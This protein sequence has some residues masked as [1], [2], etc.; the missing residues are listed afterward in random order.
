MLILSPTDRN[1]N[2]NQ[3]PMIAHQSLSPM[4]DIFY[5][6]KKF[7]PEMQLKLLIVTMKYNFSGLKYHKK[8][9]TKSLIFLINTIAFT[10]YSKIFGHWG[11]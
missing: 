11:F 8:K 2:Q 3:N 6:I 7:W 10:S 4:K 9:Q 5:D 1:E